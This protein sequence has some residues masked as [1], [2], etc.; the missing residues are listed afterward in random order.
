MKWLCIFVV[1][2]ICRGTSGRDGAGP[3]RK[4]TLLGRIA[5]Y[6][7]MFEWRTT[8]PWWP[9]LSGTCSGPVVW[10]YEFLLTVMLCRSPFRSMSVECHSFVVILGFTKSSFTDSHCGLS[11]PISLWMIMCVWNQSLSQNPD[12]PCWW[13]VAR[14]LCVANFRYCESCELT[15]CRVHYS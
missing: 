5:H 13:T 9:T 1:C 2:D 7:C 11:S 6:Q 12:T 15:P 3:G 4:C 10:S 14:C 8:L